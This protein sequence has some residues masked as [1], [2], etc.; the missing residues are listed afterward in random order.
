MIIDS[1]DLE[2]ALIEFE[3]NENFRNDI[4]NKCRKLL[5]RGFT[6][7]AYILLLATWNFARIRYFIKYLSPDEFS[8]I[9]RFIEINMKKLEGITFE[10]INLEDESVVKIIKKLYGKLR[11]YKGLEITGSIKILALRR[12][13]LFI[14]WDTEIR[15]YYK[16]S[17][18][19]PEGYV[20]FLKKMKEIFGHIKWDSKRRGKPL[21]K[22]IDE[23]N[24][25]IVVLNQNDKMK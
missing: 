15:K 4:W 5:E 24:Y 20:N 12:P 19:S 16:I 10:N 7:E 1:I 22:A 8:N 2:N 14:M 9:I 25:Y 17:D 23:Y 3:K 18:T 6:Y 11:N 13:D 21:A